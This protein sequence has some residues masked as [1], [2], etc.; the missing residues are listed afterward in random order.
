MKYKSSLNYYGAE[1]KIS[2]CALSLGIFEALRN[3]VRKL[4]SEQRVV[5]KLLFIWIFVSILG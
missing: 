1:P 3:P 5:R 4:H 2:S